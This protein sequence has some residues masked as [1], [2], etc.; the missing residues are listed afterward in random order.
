MAGV[1]GINAAET[2]LIAQRKY[3]DLK[4]RQSQIGLTIPEAF[5]HGIRHIGYRSNVDAIAELIDNSIQAYSQRVD[6]VS[7][8]TEASRSRSHP[9]QRSSM[10]GTGWRPK[11]SGLR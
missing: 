4:H 10:M 1:D 6:L 7:A 11:C 2:V 8:M 3:A 9:N 5:V